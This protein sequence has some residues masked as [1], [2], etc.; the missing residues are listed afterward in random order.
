[1]TFKVSGLSCP[2]WVSEAALLSTFEGIENTHLSLYF[3]RV[4]LKDTADVTVSFIGCIEINVSFS[5]TT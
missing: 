2:S 5:K 3:S 4:I 1:M